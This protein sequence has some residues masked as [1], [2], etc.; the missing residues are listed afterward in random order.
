MRFILILFSFVSCF[1][2]E[3]LLSKEELEVLGKRESRDF[4]YMIPTGITTKLVDCNLYR[5]KCTIGYRIKV[6]LLEFN[7]LYYENQKDAILSAKTFDGYYS[8]NWAFDYVRGEPILERY[9]VRAFQAKKV[10][11]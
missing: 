11:P 1:E 9:V 6:K 4:E 7:A 5:P 10:S 8:F 3:K 2:S